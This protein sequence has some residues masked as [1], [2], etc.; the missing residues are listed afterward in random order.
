MKKSILT[1][2]IMTMSCIASLNAQIYVGA[3]AGLAPSLFSYQSLPNHTSSPSFLNP[4][5][6]VMVEIPIIYGFS[7]QPEIQYVSRGTSLSAIRSGNKAKVI[8]KKGDYFSDYSEDNEAKEEDRNNGFADPTERFKLPDLYENIKINLGYIES[9]LML[10]YEFI[11]GGTGLYIEAGPFYS[12]GI[13]SSATSTL[14]DS[15]GKKTSDTQLIAIDG[16]TTENYTDL[17]KSYTNSYIL[18]SKPFTGDKKDVIFKKSDL[19]LAF[20]AGMYKDF[21]S[22][23]FYFDGRILLGLANINGKTNTSSTIKSR[24]LQLSVFYLFPIE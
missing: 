23:R 17:I 8:I 5:G 15:G 3:K 18:N 21:D 2:M 11:G 9:H 10:K 16:S 20:G 1:I 14:V 22:G 6:G 24:S 19:G 13:S 12:L 4:L 7:I